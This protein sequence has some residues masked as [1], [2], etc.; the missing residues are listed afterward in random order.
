MTKRLR[1][2]LR[3]V[4]FWVGFAFL[5]LYTFMTYVLGQDLPERS[6]LAGSAIMLVCVS[7]WLVDDARRIRFILPMGYGMLI[8]FYL[9]IFGPIYLF[10]TRG[11]WAFVSIGLYL[12]VALCVIAAGVTTF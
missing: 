10:Q 5:L 1:D 7:W 8:L 6:Q 4:P 9:P 2:D 12:F 11:P 3:S